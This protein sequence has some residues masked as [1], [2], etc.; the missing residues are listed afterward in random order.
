MP[1]TD[2]LV[3]AIEEEYRRLLRRQEAHAP[4]SG[5]IPIGGGEWMDSHFKAEGL[6]GVLAGLRAGKGI[7]EAIE[8][9]VDT[10]LTAVLIWN[11]RREYQVRR[12]TNRG[13][14]RESIRHHIT[15]A[16]YRKDNVPY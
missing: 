6:R 14:I 16:R 5:E 1:V 13:C 2:R 11:S 8:E 10:Y 4:R 7:L 3:R 15:L 9:G 12:T